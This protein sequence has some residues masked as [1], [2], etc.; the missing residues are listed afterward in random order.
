MSTE[1]QDQPAVPASAESAD[2]QGAE[3]PSA[4]PLSSAGASRRRLA[5]LGATGVVL[6]LTSQGAMACLC[7]TMSG[8]ASYAALPANTKVSNAPK[9]TCTPLS[10]DQWQQIICSQKGAWRGFGMRSSSPFTSIFPTTRTG[11]SS[12]TIDTILAG[13]SWDG[14]Q[15]G[16]LFMAAYLNI[17]DNR[18]S[19]MKPEMLTTMWREWDKNNTYQPGTNLPLWNKAAIVAYLKENLL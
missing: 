6:T 7:K 15:I 12:A 8:S 3:S 2:T 1:P 19:F 14:S 13:Q 16:R 11:Y 9:V 4:A 18:L 5:G 10:A 17:L